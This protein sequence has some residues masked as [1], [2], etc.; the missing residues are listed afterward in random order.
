M[1]GENIVSYLSRFEA[2][3]A[4][5]EDESPHVLGGELALPVYLKTSLEHVPQCRLVFAKMATK[6][7]ADDEK[8]KRYLIQSFEDI[9]SGR[10]MLHPLPARAP[11]DHAADDNGA[12]PGTVAGVLGHRSNQG[13]SNGSN[14]GASHGKNR[15]DRMARRGDVRQCYQSGSTDY[16]RRDCPEVSA[17]SEEAPSVQVAN[18]KNCGGAHLLRDCTMPLLKCAMCEK[19]GH[20]KHDCPFDGTRAILPGKQGVTMTFKQINSAEASSVNPHSAVAN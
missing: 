5:I 13:A 19:W 10:W 11:A 4:A 1:L 12:P 3:L 2:E 18:C 6:S 14:Q 17:E 20:L 9:H 7:H 15:P 16:L 8:Y